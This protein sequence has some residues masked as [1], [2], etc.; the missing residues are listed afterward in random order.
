MGRLI[1]PRAAAANISSEPI[2]IEPEQDE[3][4]CEAVLSSGRRTGALCLAQAKIVVFVYDDGEKRDR[5]YALCGRHYS[6]ER[7]EVEG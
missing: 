5:P 1:N 7:V 3:F 6:A 2:C 4:R